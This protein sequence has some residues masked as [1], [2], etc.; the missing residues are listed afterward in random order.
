MLAQ[1]AGSLA[2]LT[3]GTLIFRHP[4]R[5]MDR[6]FRRLLI[7]DLLQFLH[8]LEIADQLLTFLRRGHLNGL[9]LM[10]ARMLRSL[11]PTRETFHGAGSERLSIKRLLLLKVRELLFIFEQLLL[12]Q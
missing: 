9:G 5:L 7:S 4:Y 6:N 3:G 12:Q 8:F 11:G 2:G 1:R 10:R